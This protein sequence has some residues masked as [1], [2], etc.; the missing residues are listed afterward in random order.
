[1]VPLL[2]TALL[3]A[4]FLPAVIAD[5]VLSQSE[6]L[7]GLP[8]ESHRILREACPTWRFDPDEAIFQ[9]GDP[10]EA[11]YLVLSGKVRIFR[12]S[13]EGRRKILAY[14]HPGEV[15]G[16]MSLVEE[17]P[18]S[19][20][21]VAETPT[22]VLVLFRDTYLN[23]LR[24]FPLLGHNLAR[25]IAGRL[26]EMN[27]EILFLTFEEAR[28]K[29]AFALLKL[30]RHRHGE[31]RDGGWYIPI[32]HQ[33]IANLAGTS[34]ETATRVVHEL[35]DRGIVASVPGGLLLRDLDALE[36]VLYGLQ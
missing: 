20:S 18:R 30:Y 10:G 35:R 32:V 27:D 34:R 15:F 14:L 24:R 11:L 22:E 31:P 23:L 4:V 12:E 6:L 7:R 13:L 5:K 1:M 9:K 17:R 2:Y 26:R 16:E 28:S 19:A 29:V 33:E 25:I 3:F 21:A 8:A 36:Q